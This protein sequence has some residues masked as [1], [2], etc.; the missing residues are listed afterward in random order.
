LGKALWFTF[1]WTLSVGLMLIGRWV[2]PGSSVSWVL[3]GAIP[4]FLFAWLFSHT[5]TSLV[6]RRGARTMTTVTLNGAWTIH[7]P[8]GTSPVDWRFPTSCVPFQR[9]ADEVERVE[10]W[11]VLQRYCGASLSETTEKS[12][13]TLLLACGVDV[14]GY[15]EKS[16]SLANF[17][18]NRMWLAVVGAFSLIAPTA[19]RLPCIALIP[20]HGRLIAVVGASLAAFAVGILVVDGRGSNVATL[21][22][23][24]SEAEWRNR[25]V[26]RFVQ[27]SE[28]S[29]RVVSDTDGG[30]FVTVH[31]VFSCAPDA[32]TARLLADFLKGYL[33]PK[34]PQR[35]T[36]PT[37]GT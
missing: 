34:K 15:D 13:L 18:S 35:G 2:A 26:R 4:T 25:G 20:E 8:R 33:F 27:I 30:E 7:L 14:R 19:V 28:Q 22:K 6:L 9:N 11:D 17:S 37:R 21:W 3:L 5:R 32:G 24:S 23:G 10:A 36:A 1:F 31:P 29:I 12:D 16:M